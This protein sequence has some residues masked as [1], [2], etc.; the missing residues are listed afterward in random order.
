M[1]LNC[2]WDRVLFKMSPPRL[3]ADGRRLAARAPPTLS[4]Q[5]APSTPTR[6]L[7][8][9]LNPRVHFHLRPES[10]LSRTPKEDITP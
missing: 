7:P 2:G 1:P 6:P 3:R 4:T 10:R 9:P 8:P 5:A